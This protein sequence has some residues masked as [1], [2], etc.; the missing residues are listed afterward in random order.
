MA[1]KSKSLSKNCSL[2]KPY[3]GTT[4]IGLKIFPQVLRPRGLGL[5]R[6]VL[7]SAVPKRTQNHTET[8]NH[9]IT[10]NSHI[11]GTQKPEPRKLKLFLFLHSLDP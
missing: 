10:R 2:P 4:R 6:E 7:L 11:L 1:V 9:E 8:G 3:I 5:E